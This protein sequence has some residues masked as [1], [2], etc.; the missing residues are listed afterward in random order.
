MVEYKK[1]GFDLVA[2]SEAFNIEKQKKCVHLDAWLAASFPLNDFEKKIIDEIHADIADSVEAMNEEELKARLISLLFYV[3]HIDLPD[4]IRVFYERSISAHLNGYALSVV[5][6]CLVA[7]P[8]FNLPT[9]PYFFLQE[10][11]KAKGEKKDPEAQML[12]A[13]IIAQHLNN[14]QKPIYGG[15]LI[16]SIW[17]F[18]TL[19]DNNYCISRQFNTAEYNHIVQIVSILRQL[20][21]LILNR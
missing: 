17:R 16:G 21:E 5:T 13:M 6:D 18:A 7:V 2:L 15:Y 1:I 3:A 12:T 8:K 20:K 11:K 14:D 10:F 4:K 9:K 19:V